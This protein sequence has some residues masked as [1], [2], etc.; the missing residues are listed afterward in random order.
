MRRGP[1]PLATTISPQ[2]RRGDGDLED[3]LARRA[4]SRRSGSWTTV[5]SAGY[6]V[7]F[8]GSGEESRLANVPSAR[9][10]V[11]PTTSGTFPGVPGTAGGRT[12]ST[13]GGAGATGGDTGGASGRGLAGRRLDGRG[14]D[15]AAARREARRAGGSAGGT[16]RGV[17]TP[18]IKNTM[19][20]GSRRVPGGGRCRM[21]LPSSAAV[22]G[23]S[24]TSTGVRPA[25]SRR[26][27]FASQPSVE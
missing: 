8:G 23:G 1:E 3:D 26:A 17:P 4:A 5:P 18:T 7:T 24:V 25:S 13:G 2:V 22:G 20:A 6:S 27:V 12:G 19:D 15:R 21:I 9:S 10:R 16:S 14:L 11:S